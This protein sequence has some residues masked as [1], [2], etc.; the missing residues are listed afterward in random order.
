[1]ALRQ[2]SQ[3][4]NT[5]WVQR[6]RARYTEIIIITCFSLFILERTFV[7]HQTNKC[8]CG[9]TIHWPKNAKIGDTWKCRDRTCG[10][11]WTLAEEGQRGQIKPSK[12]W[13]IGDNPD[14]I[15]GSVLKTT[16][17]STSVPLPKSQSSVTSRAK[18]RDAT[19]QIAENN[20]GCLVVLLVGTLPFIAALVLYAHVHYT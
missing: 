4:L 12:P 7:P 2:S 9:K 18:P 20:T 8:T 10:T 19:R 11:I 16:T 5:V 13:A 6:K 14:F 17:P 3:P 15:P 1:M